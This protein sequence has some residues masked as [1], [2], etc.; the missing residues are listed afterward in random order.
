MLTN[1][2]SGALTP[3]GA[4]TPRAQP[5]CVP[6]DHEA[7]T[8]QEIQSMDPAKYL[9]PQSSVS[10][11]A[12]PQSRICIPHKLTAMLILVV[13]QFFR[14]CVVLITVRM[15][16]KARRSIVSRQGIGDMRHLAILLCIIA[17]AS[18]APSKSFSISA[19]SEEAGIVTITVPQVTAVIIFLIAV[20]AISGYSGFIVGHALARRERADTCEVIYFAEASLVKREATARFRPDCRSLKIARKVVHFDTCSFCAPRQDGEHTE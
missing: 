8:Y 10:P 15:D 9:P 17:K 20:G 5:M 4:A 14:M 7:Y 13:L 1:P 2:S 3:T 12:Q 18:G 11:P 19:G 16:S 6:R